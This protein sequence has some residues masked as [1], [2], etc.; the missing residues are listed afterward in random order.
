[1]REGLGVHSEV[2]HLRQVIVHRPGLEL[3]RLTPANIERWD[4]ATNFLAAEPGVVTGYERNTA[5]NAMR[6]NGIEVVDVAGSELGRGRG[7]PR[8]MTLPIRRDPVTLG[9]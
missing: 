1:M 3:S 6:R 2:G 4:D 8:C 9:G 5:T 7:G